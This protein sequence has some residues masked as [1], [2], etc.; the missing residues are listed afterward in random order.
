ME[1]MTRQVVIDPVVDHQKQIIH[2]GVGIVVAIARE[3]GLVL[4]VA[5]FAL[6]A[7]FYLKKETTARR[8]RL[9]QI[10]LLYMSLAALSIAA[11]FGILSIDVHLRVT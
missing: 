7:D 4:A 6:D 1:S 8:A 10:S 11:N 2:I 5:A 3:A 9:R